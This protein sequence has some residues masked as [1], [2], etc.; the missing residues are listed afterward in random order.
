MVETMLSSQTQQDH[1]LPPQVSHFTSTPTNMFQMSQF[2]QMSQVPQM[3]AVSQ[4]SF[5]Q[6]GL[7]GTD[8]IRIATLVEQ[9]LTDEINRLVKVRLELEMAELR[10][11]V[12]SLQ[13]D[14]KKL[15]DSIAELEV[16][17]ST[18]VDDLE[19]YVRRSCLRIAGMSEQEDED[20]D[21]SLGTGYSS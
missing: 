19:Q 3:P 5:P 8:V 7:S 16:K 20:T 13:A 11:T 14:N 10:N 17:L 18:R 9:M 15:T 6:L 2:P 12:I 4:M 1:Q 21:N